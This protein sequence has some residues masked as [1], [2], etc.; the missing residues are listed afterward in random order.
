VSEM[1]DE[2]ARVNALTDQVM[3]ALEDPDSDLNE[4]HRDLAEALIVCWK[5]YMGLNLLPDDCRLV[6]SN[7]LDGMVLTLTVAQRRGV[8]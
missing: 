3:A 6:V 1:R 4:H 7:L 5:D 8:L 2:A